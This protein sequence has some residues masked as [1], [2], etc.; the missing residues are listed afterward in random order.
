MALTQTQVSE[1]YVALFNRASEGEGN[2]YWQS[3]ASASAVA[4]EMLTLQVVQD[5]FGNALDS[6]QA[7]IEFIYQNTLNKTLADD[8]DGIAY[9]VGR[10][11]AGASRGEIVAELVAAVESY[12]DEVA[13]GTADA[14]TVRAFNQFN[15]RV[16]VSNYTA[17]NLQTAPADL[18][19]L[20][21]DGGLTVTDED[22]TVVAAEAEVDAIV[23]GGEPATGLTA[24]LNDLAADQAAKE[25]FLDAA[26]A[27]D[28]TD[29]V[30][31]TNSVDVEAGKATAQDIKDFYADVAASVGDSSNVNVTGFATKTAEVQNSYINAYQTSL[32]A[33]IEAASA[34]LPAGQTALIEAVQAREESVVEALVADNTQLG[35]LNAEIAAFNTANTL[36][37]TANP[38]FVEFEAGTTEVPAAGQVLVLSESQYDAAVDYSAGY[39]LIDGTIYRGQ[40]GSST[41][42][43][44]FADLEAASRS[45]EL[46]G[47]FAD[48]QAAEAAL[49]S[50]KTALEDAVA[51]VYLAENDA[52]EVVSDLVSAGVVS[53]TPGGAATAAVTVDVTQPVNVYAT[54][55]DKESPI[56]EVQTLTVTADATDGD[57]E[58]VVVTYPTATATDTVTVNLASVNVTDAT[59]VASAISTALNADSTFANLATASTNGSDV[60]ITYDGTL[61][62]TDV[63]LAT[64]TVTDPDATSDL[65]VSVAQTTAGALDLTS[66]DATDSAELAQALE[67]KAD[68]ADLVAEFETARDLNTEILALEEA[69]ENATAA[70]EN[71]PDNVEAPGLGVTLVDFA[72]GTLT[73]DSEVILFEDAEG[74]AVTLN[75]FGAAGEDQI[76]FGDGY[77]LVQIAGEE[78]ING[79]EGDAG[80]LEILWEE[81]GGNL[82]LYVEAETFGGNSAG[83]A[84]VT[85]VVLTGVEAADITFADGYLSAG[86]AA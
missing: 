23:T 82:T 58:E 74:T 20:R 49:E 61:A 37:V 2:T 36:D 68:F 77:S 45:A 81:A 8:P 14:A 29:N 67:A 48:K 72:T 59:A 80:A 50:A 39:L 51:D 16:E 15:N 78:G 71:E 73:S 65:A 75:D 79:N 60:V 19:V 25:A 6:D 27:L 35:N 64:V 66:V 12:A 62:G 9:W 31:S 53:Y 33:D 32:S 11:D 44:P 56:A 40:A 47:A 13:A 84:D 57:D 42:E 1:L 30:V 18:T 76:F 54:E 4:D 21:F 7:F 41:T 17:E 24:A 70:I 28:S 3:G 5:Y 55:A 43:V 69:I 22:A 34:D 38:A 26:P 52:F 85:E 86:T 83:T 63:A 10:L 46:T